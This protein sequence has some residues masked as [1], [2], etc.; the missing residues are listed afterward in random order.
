MQLTGSIHC[1]L[2]LQMRA[3]SDQGHLNLPNQQLITTAAIPKT[4]ITMTNKRKE[5]CAYKFGGSSDRC[6]SVVLSNFQEVSWLGNFF[7][8][9]KDVSDRHDI[10]YF[11][12]SRIIKYAYK[13]SNCIS[14][15]IQFYLLKETYK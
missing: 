1:Q 15:F 7:R 13:F 11:L 14:N 3:P 5:V 10:F 6:F 4:I 2:L 12:G 9:T 8:T